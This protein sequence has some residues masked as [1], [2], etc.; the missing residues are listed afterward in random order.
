MDTDSFIVYMK[1][2]DVYKYIAEDGETRF[3]TS[4]YVLEKS[5]PNGKNKEVIGLMRDEL[6]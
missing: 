6:G 1:T 4:N 3:D 5:S 2:D